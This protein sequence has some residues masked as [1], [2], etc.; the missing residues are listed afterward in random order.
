M[1]STLSLLAAHIFNEQGLKTTDFRIDPLAKAYEAADFKLEN[2]NV[3]FRKAKLTPKKN[4]QFVT[5]WK[6]NTVG[7]S[8]PYNTKDEFDCSLIVTA[9]KQHLGFFLFPKQVLAEH[10]F[11]SSPLKEGKRGFRIYP[12]WVIPESRQAEK[13]K[14]W[15][16]DYFINMNKD[17]ESMQGKFNNI[18]KTINQ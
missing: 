16:V 11:I 8:I 13:T 18:F 12:E 2:K 15:Q 7:I 17:N 5:L 4:G 1:N 10:A 6:R 14:K 9:D 3:K